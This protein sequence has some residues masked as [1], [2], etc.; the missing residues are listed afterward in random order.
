MGHD[1]GDSKSHLEQS[2]KAL[3]NSEIHWKHHVS[4][5]QDTLKSVGYAAAS[6]AHALQAIAVSLQEIS[7]SVAS[8]DE[9]TKDGGGKK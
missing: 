4:S 7:I 8:I 5:G 1:G 9:K 3:N 2:I 6:I